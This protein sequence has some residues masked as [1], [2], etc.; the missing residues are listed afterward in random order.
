MS[1]HRAR[2][3]HALFAPLGPPYDRMGATP[4]VRPGS[5]V[6]AIPRRPAPAGRRAGARRRD[7]H[8]PRRGAAPR[9]RLQGHR[10]RPERGDAR[11][12]ARA[13]RRARRAGRGLGRVAPVPRR[14]FD[15]LTF[16]YL[17]RYVDD[18]ARA[19]A[20]SRASSARAGRSG[21]SSSAS[22]AGSGGRPGTSGW[23]P[24]CRS[25]GASSRRAGTRSAASS[26][27]RS[28]S[29]TRVPRGRLLELWRARDRRRRR[30]G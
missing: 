25:R 6:A 10:P 20:S 15:H 18:P 24:A 3:A 21:W 23:A 22:R 27:R 7:R 12:R 14:D 11:A 5:A 26:A 1:A 28:A 13:A 9:P 19:L 16:T 17:L 30:V 2:A 29:S 8:R 4:L